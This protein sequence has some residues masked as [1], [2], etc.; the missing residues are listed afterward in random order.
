MWCWPGPLLGTLLDLIGVVGCDSQEMEPEGTR[1]KPCL[2]DQTLVQ[3]TAA[4][5]LRWAPGS[6]LLCII[7]VATSWWP[8]L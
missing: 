6:S 7:Y 4:I 3:D 1:E 8:D 2:Y 5:S